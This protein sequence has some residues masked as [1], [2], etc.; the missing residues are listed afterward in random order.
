MGAH[1]LHRVFA[2]FA[3]LSAFPASAILIEIDGQQWDVQRATLDVLWG[4]EAI[5]K[6]QPWWGN[7]ELAYRFADAVRGDLGVDGRPEMGDCGLA[8]WGPSFAYQA[9]VGVDGEPF[10]PDDPITRVREGFANTWYANTLTGWASTYGNCCGYTAGEFLGI[11]NFEQYTWHWGRYAV[12]T[13]VSVPEPG[14]LALLLGGGSLMLA[15]R[16]RRVSVSKPS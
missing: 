3:A 4:G 6:A 5:I 2:L 13:Q 9:S 15:L 14:T 10:E 11:T 8:C 1:M 7:S 16:R 12:A